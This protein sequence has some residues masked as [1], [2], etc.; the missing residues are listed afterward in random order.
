MTPGSHVPAGASVGRRVGGEAR[1]ERQRPALALQHPSPQAFGIGRDRVPGLG[2]H[3][4]P[5]PLVDLVLQLARLPSGVAPEQPGADQ[6]PANGAGSASRS[7]V[8][9]GRSSSTSRRQPVGRSGDPSSASARDARRT[10]PMSE[11]RATGPPSKSSAGA[12]ARSCHRGSSWSTSTP[13]GRSIADTER[14]L[15]SVVEQEDD[16]APEVRVVDGRRGDQQVADQRRR[17]RLARRRG[18]TR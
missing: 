2:R 3:H 6:R 9:T 14:T 7:T 4:V 18:R 11:L 17:G 15:E 10:R 12:V 8:P 13:P 5:R 16:P 1:H